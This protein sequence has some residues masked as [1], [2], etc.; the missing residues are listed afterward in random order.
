M[1]TLYYVLYGFA[2][3]APTA[4]QIKAGQNTNGVA[5]VASGNATGITTTQSPYTFGA[6]TGLTGSTSYRVSFVWSDGTNDSNVVTSDAFTTS[7]DIQSGAGSS[8]G[9]STAAATGEAVAAAAGASGASATAS[10]AGASIAATAGS[11]AGS[12]TVAASGAVTAAAAG[13]ASA[14]ATVSGVGQAVA[15]DSGAGASNGTSTASGAGASTATASGSVAGSATAGA[16]GSSIAAGAG[17]ASG[18]STA[19]AIGDALAAGSATGSA[20]GTSTAS[21]AGASIAAATGSADGSSTAV[22]VAPG[23]EAQERARRGGGSPRPRKPIVLRIDD[24]EFI[25]ETVD[26]ARR[27]IAQ[28][29]QLAQDAA[30]TKAQE[31]AA[32]E[33]VRMR[34]ARRAAPVVRIEAP[35]AAQEIESI[36]EQVDAVNARLQAMYVS[37]LRTALIA[38]ELQRRIDEDDEEDAITALLA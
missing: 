17:S 2:L 9:T 6:A 28:A 24:E 5:A 22:G 12:S 35:D 19:S 33:Q 11:A 13:S 31:L 3:G 7:A 21:A 25:V 38:R 32:R 23:G 15:Q 1:S 4:A 37:A 10:A 30:K 27:L 36:R 34:A 8:A 29:E 26:E 14:S 18:T 20:S 16:V